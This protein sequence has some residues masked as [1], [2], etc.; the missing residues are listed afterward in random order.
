MGGTVDDNSI[1][2][3]KFSLRYLVAFWGP[4][5]PKLPDPRKRPE[6]SAGEAPQKS[7]HRALDTDLILYLDGA[8]YLSPDISTKSNTIMAALQRIYIRKG[9]R[10]SISAAAATRDGGHVG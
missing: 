8:C 6:D 2:L 10:Y 1:L 9:Q 7:R 4:F 3:R 5:Y